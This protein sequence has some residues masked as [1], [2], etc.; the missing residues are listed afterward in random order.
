F[1]YIGFTNKLSSISDTQGETAFK[2]LSGKIISSTTNGVETKYGRMGG[3]TFWTSNSDGTVIDHVLTGE[4]NDNGGTRK[5]DGTTSRRVYN[6]DGESFQRDSS[7]DRE[8][9][10]SGPG[11]RGLWQH[12]PSGLVVM[13]HRVYDPLIGRF[14]TEDPAG[15]GNNH[16]AYAGGDPVNRWD[17]SGLFWAYNQ[18]NG[19]WVH[20]PEADD[21]G[22]N[23]SE[24]S[25]ISKG[26][27]L[28][29]EGSSRSSVAVYK[30]GAFANAE[31]SSMS[32]MSFMADGFIPTNMGSFVKSYSGGSVDM[33][34]PGKIES[35]IKATERLLAE[36][37]LII[38]DAAIGTRSSGYASEGG[39]ADRV[40][41]QANRYATDT[42]GSWAFN[43]LGNTIN[44]YGGR[45]LYS[46]LTGQGFSYDRSGVQTGG[47]QMD[48]ME[49]GNSLLFASLQI[50]TAT[51]AIGQSVR[52]TTRAFNRQLRSMD[53]TIDSIDIIGSSDF[54]PSGVRINPKFL[55]GDTMVVQYPN[56]IQKA[57]PKPINRDVDELFYDAFGDFPKIDNH[58]LKYVDSRTIRPPRG[59]RNHYS[60]D[61]L[62][63]QGEWKVWKF[64]PVE[65]E[66]A[67]DGHLYY[68][69]GMT[70]AEHALRQGIIDI[71]A[72]IK[73]ADY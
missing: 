4:Q 1:K 39:P 59:G 51:L 25:G 42:G 46:G 68:L 38:T 35:G 60:S 54:Q 8:E 21:D 71:P 67:P 73:K 12:G 44:E 11:Y 53:D 62:R 70:R 48:S 23:P 7:G 17:P 65:L 6:A 34:G 52:S 56:V 32:G 22:S 15:A 45:S 58:Q 40:R 36:P 3:K 27:N 10:E 64:T 5:A 37:L 2:M 72:Y 14:L 55:P 30:N 41:E 18:N 24:L 9:S 33:T 47:Y 50:G 28:L 29:Y 57:A 16:Y 63:G 43:A 19:D 66:L 20:F 61:K 26:T 69:N 31:L 49:R 13:G